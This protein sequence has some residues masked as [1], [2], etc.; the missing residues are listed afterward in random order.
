ME[1]EFPILYDLI[2][3]TALEWPS[4]SHSLT[5]GWLPDKKLVK[6]SNDI[7]YSIQRLILSTHT[8]NTDQNHLIIA[9]VKL[10]TIDP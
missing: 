9:Q 2:L 1:K 4:L 3:S 10:P 7:D 6:Y 8:N 5:V